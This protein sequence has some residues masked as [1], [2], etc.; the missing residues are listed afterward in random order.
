MHYANK[1]CH[2]LRLGCVVST[3]LGLTVSATQAQTPPAETAPAP[4]EPAPV[5]AAP[6][7]ASPPPEA[8]IPAVVTPPQSTIPDAAPTTP[9][10]IVAEVP[11][12]PPPAPKEDPRKSPMTMNTWLR[13]GHRLQSFEDRSKLDK[14]TQ[15]AEVNVLLNAEVIE[16]VG[17]T[18]NFAATYGATLIGG[19]G[20][21]NITGDLNIM[22]LI[23]RFD[24]DDAFHIWV[25]RMLVPSDRS[26]FSG[27]WFMSPWNYPGFFFAG[28]PLG[29]HQGPND[30]VTVWGQAGGGMFKY[31]AGA[32]ELYNAGTNPLFSGR[33]SVSLINPE[34]GYYGNS[35]FYGGKDLF[36]IGVG[37]Q[38][39]KDGS[40]SDDFIEFNADL[41]FEKNFAGAGALD[42]EGAF[43]KYEGDAETIDLSWFALA[44]F[45]I[46][47]E[48]GPGRIQPLVRVQGATPVSD[49]VD[50]SMLI[51]AQLGYVVSAFACRFA[52]G[53]Q[54]QDIAG[55][56]GGG[57][58]LGIQLQ[59]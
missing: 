40:G 33:V 26:N 53:Y 49:A 1:R 34:P 57:A 46:D 43:Y 9:P 27:P 25:G 15:D 14:L 30:G 50:S 28:P 52:L 17:L 45:I 8:V 58:F 6:V 36:A 38:A 21:G 44:S 4:A 20:G 23:A 29:P 48:V 11:P 59:K 22:D 37:M 24:L 39:Q 56:T 19:E 41:L 42:I 13:L 2:S 47:A 10:V 16:K 7:A 5:I 32:F 55:E 31:Y 54:Y 12:P 18:A 51:D 35:T 3:L